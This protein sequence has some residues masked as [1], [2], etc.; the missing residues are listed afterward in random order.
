VADS[1]ARSRSID[2][3]YTLLNKS[4]LANALGVHR[5]F[6]TAMG[7]AGFTFNR[8]GRTTLHLAHRWLEQNPSFKPQ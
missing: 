8:G 4:Q 3:R 2:P 5:A 7:A 6:V 1:P